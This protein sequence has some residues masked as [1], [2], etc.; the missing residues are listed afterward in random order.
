ME[1]D[2]HRRHSESMEILSQSE[3]AARLDFM[4][5]LKEPEEQ[6]E[7]Q[8]CIPFEYGNQR[9]GTKISIAK[10][11]EIAACLRADI[12]EAEKRELFRA[13]KAEEERCKRLLEQSAKAEHE[14]NVA[15]VEIAT[16]NRR[17][18]AKRKLRRI[19]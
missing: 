12:A 17:L 13:F 2:L 4:S 11:K 9:K 19:A 14:L 1:I 6:R 10:A 15:R 16:L 7:S 18:R 8:W 5:P 3:L